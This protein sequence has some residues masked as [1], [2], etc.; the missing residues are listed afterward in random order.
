MNRPKLNAIPLGS[1]ARIVANIEAPVGVFGKNIVHLV[2][3]TQAFW[4]SP[5]EPKTNTLTQKANTY[6]VGTRKEGTIITHQTVSDLVFKSKLYNNST[7]AIEATLMDE[8]VEPD[9]SGMEKTH[10][11]DY[12]KWIVGNL[13]NCG[14]LP[15]HMTQ[16]KC[17]DVR[18]EPDL[19]AINQING[20]IVK[21]DL[22]IST[23]R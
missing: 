9:W 12:G 21:L 6:E 13:Q 20:K 23:Y 7:T 4:N 8:E 5:T 22:E 3:N 17:Y 10:S 2:P 1:R 14:T 18:F 16:S 19:T 15:Q 11:T